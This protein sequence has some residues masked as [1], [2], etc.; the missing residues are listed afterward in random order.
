MHYTLVNRRLATRDLIGPE[1]TESTVYSDDP[2]VCVGSMD[3]SESFVKLRVSVG[4]ER[5]LKVWHAELLLLFRDDQ[6]ALKDATEQWMEEDHPIP[7]TAMAYRTQ[8]ASENQ[9]FF[10]MVMPVDHRIDYR[11]ELGRYLA[12]TMRWE[13]SG[14][15]DCITNPLKI[16]GSAFAGVHGYA[17]DLVRSFPPVPGAEA[18]H[19]EVK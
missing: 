10:G 15:L 16:D 19:R 4:L 6:E 18:S 17:H 14:K 7:L 3:V 9:L 8:P 5:E 1:L 13:G 12:L 11:G 2:F